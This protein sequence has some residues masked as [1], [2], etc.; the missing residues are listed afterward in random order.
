MKSRPRK[1]SVPPAAKTEAVKPAPVAPAAE[2]VAPVTIEAVAVEA[3]VVAEPVAVVEAP[4][5]MIETAKVEIADIAEIAV[6]APILEVAAE[7]KAAMIDAQD[8]VAAAQQHIADAAE[9]AIEQNRDQMAKVQASAG[10]LTAGV[11][12]SITTLSKGISELNT[13]AFEV[14]KLNVESSFAHM[15]ALFAA[16]SLPEAWQLQADHGRRQFETFSVQ[17]KE[18]SAAA[19]K[20]ALEAA[21]P[22]KQKIEQA[23]QR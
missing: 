22:L 19:S 21:Q 18:L 10:E 5:E 17:T 6:P 1:I 20:F 2:P 13:K 16:K 14:L 4:V 8:Q 12:T 7:A 3:P 9:K 11:E 15:K 23:L